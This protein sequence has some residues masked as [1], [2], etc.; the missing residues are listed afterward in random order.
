MELVILA[1]LVVLALMIGFASLVLW[2]SRP[3]S[4]AVPE[5]VKE[6]PYMCAG[7]ADI[8]AITKDLQAEMRDVKAAVAEGIEHVDR[9]ENRIRATVKRARKEL[10]EGGATSP[11]LEAEAADLLGEHA[12]GGAEA[13]MHLMPKSVVESRSS[14]PGVSPEQLRRVRGI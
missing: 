1:G 7:C 12:A 8:A 2:R 6:T 14:V 5:V 10:S 4:N 3:A 13:A 11:G 9:V